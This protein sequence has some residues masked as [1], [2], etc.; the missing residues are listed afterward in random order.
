[1]SDNIEQPSITSSFLKGIVFNF[2]DGNNKIKVV[3]SMK[4]GRET[5]YFNDEKVS[6]KRSMKRQSQHKIVI[7]GTVYEVEFNVTS[8]LDGIIKCT[9]IKDDVHLKTLTYNYVEEIQGKSPNKSKKS[10]LISLTLWTICGFFI[11]FVLAYLFK[12]SL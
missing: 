3:S 6:E 5:V 8:L 9:L 12:V 4:S 11:G 10:A 2:S 1:M 7:N